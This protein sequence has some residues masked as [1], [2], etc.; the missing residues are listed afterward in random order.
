MFLHLDDQTRVHQAIAD[1]AT[2]P[3]R[4]KKIDL[5]A[6]HRDGSWRHL[7]AIAT[8]LLDDPDVRGIVVNSRDVT[9][10]VAIRNALQKNERTLRFALEAARM[11]VWDWDATTGLVTWIGEDNLSPHML[12]SGAFQTGWRDSLDHV[13]PEDRAKLL[14]VESEEQLHATG[15]FEAENRILV[16]GGGIRWFYDRGLAVER[17]DDGQ[18]HRMVGI[19]MDITDRKTA[20]AS[21]R[22]VFDGAADAILVADSAGR[23]IDA[24]RAATELLGY[25]R[26]ELLEM[27]VGDLTPAGRR[28][29][30]LSVIDQGNVE[31]ELLRKDGRPVSV[32]GHTSIVEMPTGTMRVGIVRDLT[33]RK[34]AARTAAFL[35]S[36]V[37]SSADA[38]IGITADFCVASWNESAARLYG[39]TADE[40]VGQ[41]ISMFYPPDLDGEAERPRYH[42]LMEGERFIDVET[43]R[44][45]KDGS[46]VDVCLTVAPICDASGLVVAYS[47]VARDLTAQ[48]AAEAEMRAGAESFTSIF[49]AAAE[50]LYIHDEDVIVAVN[51]TTAALIGYDD[52][53]IIGRSIFDIVAPV[54]RDL[55][56]ATVAQGERLYELVALRADGS[57]FP[58]EIL[59]RPVRYQERSLRLVT[60]RDLTA[61]KASEAAIRASEARFRA[62]V[63][64]TDEL[65]VVL[66]PNGTMQ[67]GSPALERILGYSPT[68]FA[69]RLRV[70]LV[71]PDDWA[72]VERVWAAVASSETGDREQLEYRVQG[73]HGEWVWLSCV[74]TNHL[75][76]PAIHG[77][78]L[79]A[80]DVTDA[81]HRDEELRRLA[82]HDPLTDLPNRTLFTDRLGDALTEVVAHCRPLTVLFLDLDGFKRVNDSFGHAVGDRLLVAVGQRLAAGL[83][84]DATLARF[85]GDEFTVLLPEASTV[86]AAE[87]AAACLLER[88]RAPFLL[89]GREVFADASIGVAQSS[90]TLSRPEDLLR[91]ADIALYQA[92]AAGRA[93]YRTFESDMASHISA[94][95][96]LE[97]ELRRAVERGELR[98]YFQPE[99]DLMT[100][101]IVGAEALVRWQHPRRGLLTPGEFVPI[102]EESELIVSIGGWVLSE[103][104]RQ[105]LG[106]RALGPAAKR[107][108]VSVNLTARQL[109]HPE[110]IGEIRR[111]TSGAGL[112]ARQL[113]LEI[114]ERTVVD[115]AEGETSVLMRLRRLG[116]KLAIDD[117]GT[118]YSSLGYLR[119]W[120]VDTL[121]IDRSFVA[122]IEGDL[123]GQQLV[124][125]M[126]GLAHALSANVTAEGI[127]TAGQLEWL[128]SIGVERGQGYYFARPLPADEFAQL[129]SRNVP[130][131]LGVRP[132]TSTHSGTREAVT[133]R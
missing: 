71:Y 90:P 55:V 101:A 69:E 91:A 15:A 16:I 74:V 111:A 95:L 102:A 79:N 22:A 62:L 83:G 33:K 85:G 32:E 78:V 100:G 45:R 119:R 98:V 50:A 3:G 59:S 4:V 99:V 120:P 80:R 81:K 47:A 115:D 77:I 34:E 66:N 67:Y 57:T 20:E 30:W 54:S 6:R 53:S 75:D 26:D 122:D 31:A 128:R 21:Y 94:R 105:T 52:A 35:A 63:Q 56:M 48:K 43:R 44:L 12:A 18:I 72:T 64:N 76:D 39:Y 132:T 8:N 103:A 109:R 73:A 87:A 129:L 112:S 17:G 126:A 24:N 93:T 125:A 36:I 19:T 124:A 89:E 37:A 82:L 107:L 84:A 117:F 97:S 118:G 127:E 130:Y 96:E 10:N 131:D 28:A 1:L 23:Y 65:I 92:K 88:L 2:I 133:I 123:G 5:R 51:K 27:S 11:G 86:R 116:V 121:K 7:E 9:E 46:V 70:D 25:Q 60:I 104:C 58:A 13:H 40:V 110:L 113:K 29:P 49:Y 14:S 106:W 61:R 108:V 38:I 42:H 114:T 68:V 41:S